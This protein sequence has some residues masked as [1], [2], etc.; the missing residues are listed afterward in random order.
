MPTSVG[1]QTILQKIGGSDN[2]FLTSHQNCPDAIGS[3]CA[4]IAYL[5]SQNKKFYPYLAEPVPKLLMSLPESSEIKTVKP[6]LDV[7]DLC[8]VVD[9]GDLKQT[10][11][12]RELQA[13][14]NNKSGKNTVINIDHHETNEHF[15][16]L[17]LVDHNASST[18]EIIYL[19]LETLD[20]PLSPGIAE[21]L[22]TGIVGDT[23]N[24]TNAA[25]NEQSLK[26]A[27]ELVWRGAN[28][29]QIIQHLYSTE[30]SINTLR[31][32]GKI[33]QRLTYNHKYDIAISYVLQKDLK[34]C[35]VG[36]EVVEVVA[37]FLNYIR[38]IKAGILI[39]ERADGTFK[40][41]LRSTYPGIDVSEL[42]K[43][44]GGGGHKKA[45][46][47]SLKNLGFNLPL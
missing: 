25:T 43:I 3:I 46:G 7:F 31:L 8:L 1:Y 18:C 14:I 27:A 44:L 34:E 20:Y 16:H 40:V 32:W 11:L 29:F 9:A 28:I 6:N 12:E 35:S 30:E 19:L 37:N 47:F 21:A 4:L 38:R 36:E 2:I 39:K 13:I 45:A 17:N 41:S 24:F 5:K 10:H 26:I 33:F 15:G 42:A 22:L 23:G